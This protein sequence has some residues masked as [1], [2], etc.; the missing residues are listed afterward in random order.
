MSLQTAAIASLIIEFT[1]HMRRSHVKHPTGRQIWV[2]WQ[3]DMHLNDCG[4]HG[5]AQFAD[6]GQQ[7]P[8]RQL[9]FAGY[10]LAQLPVDARMGKLL[11]VAALLG[12][13]APALT[14]AACLSH[15]SPFSAPVG[16][17]DQA[18][19]AMQGLAASGK[20]SLGSKV[21]SRAVTE[22]TQGLNACN[23]LQ[24]QPI[25][26]AL[27]IVEQFPLG[28]VPSPYQP[29]IDEFVSCLACRRDR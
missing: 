14:V 22:R 9:F 26:C 7:Q 11:V 1:V 12:C 17:Q 20:L 5:E 3:L 2:R 28:G 6:A 16:Q 13:L 18:R 10:H 4:H 19:R 27:L 21:A 15:K 24:E 29:I 23:L 8:S 25:A